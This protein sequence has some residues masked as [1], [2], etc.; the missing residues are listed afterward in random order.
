MRKKIAFAS[1]WNVDLF[2]GR[3]SHAPIVAISISLPFS[4]DVVRGIRRFTLETESAVDWRFVR[5]VGEKTTPIPAHRRPDGFIG[6][7]VP[8]D[9]SGSLQEESIPFVNIAL[10]SAG[11]ERRG[12]R[13]SGGSTSAGLN[14]RETTPD[15]ACESCTLAS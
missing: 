6:G 8:R 9:L 12:N 4:F 7:P 11:P 14:E 1:K 5:W 15:R 3:R 2:M 13:V 10:S